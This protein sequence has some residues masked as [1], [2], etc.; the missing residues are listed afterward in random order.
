MYT[1]MMAMSP[2]TLG[3]QPSSGGLTALLHVQKAKTL[4]HDRR[5]GGY[6]GDGE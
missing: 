6:R 3:L 4:Q 5:I 1:L 2:G